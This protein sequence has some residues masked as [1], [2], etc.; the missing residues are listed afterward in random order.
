MT[1]DIP[2]ILHQ[3]WRTAEL[4]APF[5][6]FRASW[7]NLHRG[8]QHQI[9]DDDRIYRIVCDRLPRWLPTF[10]ALPLPIMRADL[11]RYLI[12]FLDG[13]V[14][15]DI[16][17]VSYR[18]CDELLENSN[19][20]LGTEMRVSSSLQASFN[21]ARPAQIANFIFAAT[22]EH[23]FLGSVIENIAQRASS[24]PDGDDFVQ[25]TTG[26]RMFTRATYSFLLSQPDSIK[27]LPRI[28][29]NAPLELPRIGPMAKRIYVRHICFGTWRTENLTS[30]RLALGLR[31]LVSVVN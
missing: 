4:P 6:A 16:D 29:W 25:E 24:P 8:W 3:T 14:Y 28:N 18:A 22:P 11:F 15:A 12:V 2:K 9:Y 23:P 21:Y 10:E 31:R 26:P 13:G 19:C 17:T 1:V 27:I 7:L 30:R 20:V 5:K